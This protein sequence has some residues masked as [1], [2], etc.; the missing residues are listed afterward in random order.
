MIALRIFLEFPEDRY[1][2]VEFSTLAVSIRIEPDEG[3]HEHHEDHSR[4]YLKV[5]ESAEPEE[6][7]RVEA[8]MKRLRVLRVIHHKASSSINGLSRQFV[9]LNSPVRVFTTP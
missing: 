1:P 3:Q 2:K 5:S 7:R 6:G 4:N 8:L 9:G